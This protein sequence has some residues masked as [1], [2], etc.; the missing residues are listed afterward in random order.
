M[1][2]VIESDMFGGGLSVVP[3]SFY[4]RQGHSPQFWGLMGVI[5]PGG[6]NAESKNYFIAIIF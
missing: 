6:C 5:I 2:L 3:F 1:P 4:G